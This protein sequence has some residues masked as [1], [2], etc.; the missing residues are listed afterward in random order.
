MSP[1]SW[2]CQNLCLLSLAFIIDWRVVCCP[3]LGTGSGSGTPT[4]PGGGGVVGVKG[5]PDINELLSG[6]LYRSRKG[7]AAAA[8]EASSSSSSNAVSR[9][10]FGAST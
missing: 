5:H 4:G 3:S 2:Q 1:F 6:I 7:A 10:I 9:V 8:N